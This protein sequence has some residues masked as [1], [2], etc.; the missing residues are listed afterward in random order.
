[1]KRV[2][3][4]GVE[5]ATVDEGAGHPVVFLH[6]FPL[7]HRM[8]LGQ[9]PSLAQRHRVIA[10]DLRGFGQS[11]VS[12]ECVTMAEF[13]EDV[14][15]LLDALGVVEPITLVG[16]SMGGYVALE[17]WRQF[18]P[19]LRALV[20]C[21]TRA[22]AD[23]PEVAAGRHVTAERVVRE[24]AAVVAETMLPRLFASWAGSE[25]AWVGQ[26]R[27]MILAADPRA[28]AAAARGMAERRD[29]TARLPEIALPVLAVVGAQDQITPP[30]EMRSMAK[31]LPQASFVEIAQAGHMAPLEN[32]AEVN[33]ALL[34]FLGE[35][36]EA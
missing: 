23:A 25:P 10:P 30:A 35:V 4:R 28:I 36:T 21:D 13:A 15:L 27:E 7:D 22:A 12:G 26:T 32:P 5:L 29:F 11:A 16:L 19:R 17:F 34:A 9:I 8:W 18:V 6:G 1:M 3:V 2:S 24:G 31:A 14:A 33:A 20:L